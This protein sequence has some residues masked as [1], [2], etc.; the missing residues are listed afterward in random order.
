MRLLDKKQS[1]ALA[2]DE[3][4]KLIDEGV[5]LAQRVDALREAVVTEEGILKRFREEGVQAVQVEIDEKVRLKDRLLSEIEVLKEK[6]MVLQEPLDAKWR[7]VN[8]SNAQLLKD[9]QA[10][11]EKSYILKEREE[12]LENSEREVEIEKGRAED[13][14]HR[15]SEKLALADTTLKDAREDSAKI[16]IQAQELLQASMLQEKIVQ[17]KGEVVEEREKEVE[18]V[19][20][21]VVAKERNLAVREKQL[22]DRYETLE[23]T[24]KRIK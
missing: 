20:Q 14:A 5:K 21:A 1:N 15:A 6:R 23:R 18:R 8:E 7:E 11:S 22:K 4:K 3:R 17:R 13:I 24:L 9:K 10:V 16:R 12:T 2:S 19:W